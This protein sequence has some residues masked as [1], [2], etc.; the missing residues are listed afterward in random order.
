MLP[1]G[2]SYPFRRQ[3]L[4]E[5]LGIDPERSK[6]FHVVGDSMMPTLP[7]GS[8]ILVDY[9][10]A[11]PLENRLYVFKNRG[12]ILVRRA[13]EFPVGAWWWCSD[14]PL[15]GRIR[16]SE[17]DVVWGEVRWVGHGLDEGAAHTPL[18]EDA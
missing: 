2:G 6:V 3:E 7:H 17:E 16:R 11:V 14:H 18:R 9:T 5:T 10:R 13:R 15:G 8:T 1:A 12:D 4:L